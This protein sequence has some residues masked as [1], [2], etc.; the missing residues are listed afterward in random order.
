MSNLK[1]AIKKI[2]LLKKISQESI[3]IVQSNIKDEIQTIINPLINTALQTFDWNSVNL[4]SETKF[5]IN[6]DILI[7]PNKGCSLQNVSFTHKSGPKLDPK[8]ITNLINIL[9][10]IFNNTIKNSISSK[11]KTEK[12]EYTYQCSIDF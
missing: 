11:Y 8:D 4:D 10:P 2:V 1:N 5:S 3:Q 9:R 6:Y 12:Y 7:K